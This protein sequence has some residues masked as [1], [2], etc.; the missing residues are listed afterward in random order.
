MHWCFLFFLHV[1]LWCCRAVLNKMSIGSIKGRE[2]I[3]TEL[4]EILL[5]LILFGGNIGR[6]WKHAVLSL[7]TSPLQQY[8][9][10]CANC[11]QMHAYTSIHKP[12]QQFTARY[13]YRLTQTGWQVVGRQTAQTLREGCAA[14]VWLSNRETQRRKVAYKNKHTHTGILQG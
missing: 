5:S 6:V 13:P 14:N 7:Q 4:S 1:R 3:D 10:N 12:G 11:A 9:T 8:H 2:E